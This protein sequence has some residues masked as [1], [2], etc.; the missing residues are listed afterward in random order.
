MSANL[1]LFQDF[2]DAY[3][4]KLQITAR[5]PPQD[6]VSTF[7][8]FKS[9]FVFE[10]ALWDGPMMDNKSTEISDPGNPT[11]IYSR[12]APC[13]VPDSLKLFHRLYIGFGQI[14]SIT[15][16]HEMFYPALRDEGVPLD[17]QENAHYGTN[18][19]YNDYCTIFEDVLSTDNCQGRLYMN[20]NPES[21][22]YEH[23]YSF[24]SSD[25]GYST[26]VAKSFPLLLARMLEKIITCNSICDCLNQMWCECKKE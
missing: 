8:P 13:R 11:R 26:C 2:A 9:H 20:M 18:I 17:S 4:P 25:D 14:E 15:R 5:D 19:Y 22:Y 23:I 16:C 21:E 6:I 12:V 1:K 24:T 7:I 10:E 3:G